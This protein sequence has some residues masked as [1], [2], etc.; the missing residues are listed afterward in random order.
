MTEGLIF[1][2]WFLLGIIGR[3]ISER[4]LI[5]SKEDEKT[6]EVLLESFPILYKVID[7]IIT[8]LYEGQINLLNTI[9]YLTL[10]YIYHPIRCLMINI[11]I[12]IHWICVWIYRRYRLLKMRRRIMKDNPSLTK[13]EALNVLSEIMNR[14]ARRKG[15]IVVIVKQK[16]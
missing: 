5:T 4:V 1:L 16:L 15:K 7:L 3:L 9:R 6:E 11:Y 12:N 8:I 10:K 13:K 14:W 2:M